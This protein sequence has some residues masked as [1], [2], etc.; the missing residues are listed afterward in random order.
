MKVV[1]VERPRVA[2]MARWM[3]VV[4]MV[5]EKEGVA[6]EGAAAVRVAET[7]AAAA[8]KAMAVVVRAAAAVVRATVAV[9]GRRKVAGC[10]NQWKV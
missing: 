1:A 6:M 8:V 9:K 5:R 4:V 2:V 3:A 10:R 7:M